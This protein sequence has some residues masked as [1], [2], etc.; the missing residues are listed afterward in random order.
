MRGVGWRE[1]HAA[2]FLSGNSVASGSLGHDWRISTSTADNAA[3]VS[4]TL[5]GQQR[6]AALQMVA[7]AASLVWASADAVVSTRR[8]RHQSESLGSVGD[9]L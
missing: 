8:N 9:G 3:F 2:L 1:C 4:G 6:L 7:V 5:G